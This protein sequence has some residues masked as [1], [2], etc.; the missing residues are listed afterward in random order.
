M[1]EALLSQF[2]PF[3]FNDHMLLVQARSIQPGR[4]DDLLCLHSAM[5]ID[6]LNLNR[7]RVRATLMNVG[8]R[9]AIDQ[10]AE[11]FRATVVAARIHLPLTLC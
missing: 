11:K 3:T 1:G 9:C 7:H 2:D 8:N 5:V 6:F 4:F 10:E